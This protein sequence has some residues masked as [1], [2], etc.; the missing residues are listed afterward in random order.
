MKPNT[1][2]GTQAA[3]RFAAQP[4]LDDVRPSWSLIGSAAVTYVG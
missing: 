3:R 1:S 4:G 2:L